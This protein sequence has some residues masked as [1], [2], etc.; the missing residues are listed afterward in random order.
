MFLEIIAL[1]PRAARARTYGFPGMSP[2]GMGRLGS[3]GGRKPLNDPAGWRPSGNGNPETGEDQGCQIF[4]GA[5]FPNRR[6]YT[7]RP[8]N[9]PNEHKINQ[10]SNHFP[11][12]S[13]YNIPKQGK[14]TKWQKIYKITI[15]YTKWQ[16]MFTSRSFAKYE[17]WY[18]LANVHIFVL[19]GG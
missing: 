16:K 11:L 4:L 2:G 5:T 13:T 18:F 14:Y 19:K 10:M 8:R 9:I 15:K 12:L 17:G 3:I 1:A 7:K 6:K